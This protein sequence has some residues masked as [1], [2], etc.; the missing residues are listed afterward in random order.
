MCLELGDGGRHGEAQRWERG[1]HDGPELDYGGMRLR[2]KTAPCHTTYSSMRTAARRRSSGCVLAS[3]A[4]TRRCFPWLWKPL[5]IAFFKGSTVVG[6][7]VL[8]PHFC[9]AG[10]GTPGDSLIL[11]WVVPCR[12]IGIKQTVSCNGL[13]HSSIVFYFCF[14]PKFVYYNF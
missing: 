11:E 4:S 10:R 8:A 13:T 2:W 14:L 12:P 7:T 3:M 5:E 6:P 1:C 9:D